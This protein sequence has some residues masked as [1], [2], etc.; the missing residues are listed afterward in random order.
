MSLC[1]DT[2]SGLHWQAT[3]MIFGA[4]AIP[5]ALFSATT[6]AQNLI[7][8]LEAAVVIGGVVAG[9]FYFITSDGIIPAFVSDAT[10]IIKEAVCAI[11]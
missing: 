9:A 2:S 6:G 3:L 7:P 5:V 10:S 8:G 4:T 1:D 11:I